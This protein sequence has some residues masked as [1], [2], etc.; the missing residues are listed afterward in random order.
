MNKLALRLSSLVN[1]MPRSFWFLWLGTVINRLGGFAVPFLMLYLTSQLGI[2]P[3]TAAFMVSVLGA[4]SFL[5]QLFGG[6]LADRLGRRPVMLMSFF[7]TPAVMIVLGLARSLWLLVTA[8]FVLGFFVDLYRPAVSA[9]VTDLV[10]A[11]KRTRAFGFLYWAINLGAAL[12]PVIAGFMANFDYFLLFLGD[13]VTTF[14]FG[15]VVLARIP[16]TQP[17]EAG[18]AAHTG[19]R[20]RM[21]DLIREPV[22]LAFVLLSLL[23]AVVYSQHQVTLPLA[24]ADSGLRPADYGLA[25]SVNGALIILITLQAIRTIERWPRF[26]AMGAAALLIGAGFGLTAL[27]NTLPFYMVTIAI[28]T[29]G[30][31]IGATIAPVII[32]ELAPVEKRGLYQGIQGS[33]W[34]LAFFIGPALGGF[35]Y[36]HY[37]SAVLWAACFVI[38]LVACLGFLALSLPA[39]RR[40]PQTPGA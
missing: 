31:I 33:A 40:L 23:F 19:L 15:L 6:E 36:E 3:A 28:W 24:I 17:R 32:A 7:V 16:E 20:A 29:L 14:I 13:A 39:K 35:V 11:G 27:A 10:P 18:R 25:I 9:A 34:G 8:M 4:G 22:L 12:A 38:G 5:S 1:E 2:S 21:K 37:G 30:E 26:A